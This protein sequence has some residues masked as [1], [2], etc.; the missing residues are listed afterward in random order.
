MLKKT[1]LL[2]VFSSLSL[3][4]LAQSTSNF[5]V[6]PEKPQN[7]SPIQ[8]SYNPVGTP[9]ASAKEISAVVYQYINYHWNA[10]D[11]K[12]FLSEKKWKASF[13]TPIDCGLLAFKFKSP[14]TVDNNH[15][16]GYFVMINDKDRKGALAPGAYAGWGLA[17]SPKYGK[18]IPGYIKFKGISD[19]AT[20]HWL[21]QEIYYNQKAKPILAL[22][23]AIALKGYLGEKAADRLQLAGKYMT[24]PEATE[25]DLL[26]GKYLYQNLLVKKE[27][28]DSIQQVLITKFPSGSL[29]RLQ[30]YRS[31]SANSNIDSMISASLRFLGKFPEY[32]TDEKFDNENRINYGIVY[33]N[34]MVFS[35]MKGYKTDYVSKY[36]DSLSYSMLPSVYYK[37]IWIPFHRKEGNM[38]QFAQF[39]DILVRRFENFKAN[40]PQNLEYFSPKEWEEQYRKAFVSTLSAT[41]IGLLN[42]KEKY[43]QALPY[44]I[45]AQR[46]LKYNNAEINNEHAII[47]KKLKMSKELENVLLKS[48]YNNQASP[49]MIA[50]LEEMYVARKKSKAGFDTYLES[51]KNPAIKAAEESD[52]KAN[53]IKKEMPAWS[54][55][56]L[57]GKTVNSSDLKGKTVILD[58]W[59]TWCVPCKASFPGMKIAV[60]KYSKDPNVVFYFVDTEERG[61]TY[62]EEIAKYIKENNLPFNVLFDNKVPGEKTNSEVFSKI[63]KAFKISGIPQKLVI[64]KNGFLRF[65]S[66]GFS[67]S[68]TGLA[69]EMSGL[70]ELTKNAE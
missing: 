58:F 70:I 65:L 21:N 4:L 51:L 42:L 62:K 9:L 35:T 37:L 17:R 46:E 39:S 44:A 20:F 36:A 56:D 30:A 18:D 64:D 68:A 38:D 66:L 14:D 43:A 24:R 13:K 3:G 10:V 1:V 11:L 55:K 59:A 22:D 45:D 50:M 26:N 69:D 41:H 29:A 28:V 40:R 67:G 61:E 23:Y 15:D 8:I 47:L 49:E 54:M 27:T 57:S 33:Q 53:M 16:L 32:K 5:T 2:I 52:Q 48:M 31:I 63:C 12:L 6:T 60:E 25:R 7:G 34:L 19:T